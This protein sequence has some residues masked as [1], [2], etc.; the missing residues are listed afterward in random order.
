MRLS[1]FRIFSLSLFLASGS[2][3]YAG[4][5]DYLSNQSADYIRMFSRNGAT[6]GA[7]IAVYNPAGTAFLKKGFYFQASNQFIFKTHEDDMN[8]SSP[9]NPVYNKNYKTTEPSLTVPNAVAIY[10]GDKWAAYFTTGI[11]AGG[12]GVKYNDGIPTFAL[13]FYSV[14]QK[15]GAA[16]ANAYLGAYTGNGALEAVSFYPQATIG[17][18]YCVT[19]MISVS[20][21]LRYVYG[22][23]TY[24]GNGTYSAAGKLELDAKETAQG[25]GAIIAV[26][27]RPLPG[28]AL[29][30]RYE[31]E[32]KLDFETKIN[33]GKDFSWMA[34]ASK[35]QSFFVDGKSRRK[36]LPAMMGLGASYTL[37][38][39]LVCIASFD[40]F[41][42]GQADNSKDDPSE[43][44]YNDGYNDEYDAFGWEAS[45][46]F[47]Y[48]VIPK[49]LRVS[50]GYM[51]SKIGGNSDVYNDFEL[52]LDSHSFGIGGRVSPVEN[53]DAIL[54]LSTTRYVD[55]KDA[56]GYVTYKKTNYIVGLGC[57]YRI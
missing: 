18:S 41:F 8:A 38:D 11:V 24:K 15:I 20:L 22:Y 27:V 53:L 51:Y 37:F 19:D 10:N 33:D 23:K 2:S 45:L 16:G 17:G 48:I 55:G 25:I 29:T 7:D 46:G 42:I 40:G 14:A 32:T 12:G 52:S 6:E 56:K 5:I 9:I 54:G 21:G 34:G 3:L 44:I 49:I 57:E 50:A 36:D 13:Y 43:A 47:E 26:D 39:R 31:T 30:A 28:L 35:V 1:L 4:S